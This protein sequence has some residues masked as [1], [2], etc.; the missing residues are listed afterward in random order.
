MEEAEIN[1]STSLPIASRQNKGCGEGGFQWQYTP[2][3]DERWSLQAFGI[4][5]FYNKN[6]DILHWSL[7]TPQP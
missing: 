7:A 4:L 5:I 3:F 1:E 2:S 6:F